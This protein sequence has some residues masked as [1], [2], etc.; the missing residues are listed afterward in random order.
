MNTDN[1]IDPSQLQQQQQQQYRQG[2][3]IEHEAYT[4]DEIIN[5]FTLNEIQS[6]NKLIHNNDNNNNEKKKDS[7]SRSHQQHEHQHQQPLILFG[8]LKSVGHVHYYLQRLQQGINLDNTSNRDDGDHQVVTGQS[9]SQTIQ[10]TTAAE[11]S[12]N[13]NTNTN[14][15]ASSEQQLQQEQQ[16]Q[17]QKR[18][19]REYTRGFNERLGPNQ[20]EA[21]V[22]PK[23]YRSKILRTFTRGNPDERWC[24]LDL[25]ECL[26]EVGITNSTDDATSAAT[27]AFTSACG[28]SKKVL[29]AFSSL[30]VL[31]RDADEENVNNEVDSSDEGSV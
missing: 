15:K 7:I 31:L 9:S 8:A 26:M 16:Q 18:L 29:C 1:N 22:N 23:S 5:S 28:D 27:A 6:L 12:G 14:T 13:T 3:D 19:A 11:E 4:M 10:A 30:E 25:G 24:E 20:V 21:N 2:S 17:N